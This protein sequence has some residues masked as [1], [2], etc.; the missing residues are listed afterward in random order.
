[1]P[2][3]KFNLRHPVV[4]G[5]IGASW[6]FLATRGVPVGGPIF[7]TRALSWPA[8]A[9]ATVGVFV[10]FWQVARVGPVQRWVKRHAKSDPDE[11]TK[12][13]RQWSTYDILERIALG[14]TTLIILGA[15]VVIA[16][17]DNLSP[18][19]AAQP[20]PPAPCAHA[21]AVTNSRA[22]PNPKYALEAW[23]IVET[24]SPLHEPT[25]TAWHETGS[26]MVDAN[27]ERTILRTTPAAGTSRPYTYTCVQVDT[28]N[29]GY[30]VTQ[31][32][33]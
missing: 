10:L 28:T 8:T 1:M 14:L 18:K 19:P 3:P 31:A 32:G 22:A 16:E 9:L 33:N 26:S 11:Q 24:Q 6:I 20:A 25:S 17:G 4:A 12:I 30:Q 13:F 5:L 7:A 15:V 27:D 29:V 2:D 21:S 23:L